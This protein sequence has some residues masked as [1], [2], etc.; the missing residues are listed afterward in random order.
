MIYILNLEMING[1]YV[2]ITSMDGI[3]DYGGAVLKL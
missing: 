2:E 1:K 3:K